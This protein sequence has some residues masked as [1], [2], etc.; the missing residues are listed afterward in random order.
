MIGP[1]TDSSSRR[2]RALGASLAIAGSLCAIPA[3]A[4]PP[5][6]AVD[7][8]LTVLHLS[9]SA[10]RAIR[11]DRL[12]VQLRVETTAGNPKQVQADINR[13]MG[14]ALAKVKTVTGV[15]PE[16]GSY[17][18]YE[19]RQ[20]NVTSR[21]RGSQ[22]LSLVDRD[23][24]ELLALVGDLQND[25]LAVSSLSFELSPEAAHTAQDE[26]TNEALNRLRDRAERI[27]MEL[28]L[29]FQ[30]YRDIRVGNVGGDRPVPMRAMAMA[31]AAPVAPPVGEAGDA[32]VQVSVEADVVLVPDDSKGP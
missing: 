14:N 22:S 13:R 23:F 10:D 28:H 25:G 6:P 17:A 5:S 7:E 21:W 32:M 1:A 11:R 31:T 20:Q 26:L 16:T 19:E 27:A 12:H 8:G 29:S 9:E 3:L 30:R 2:R 24:A 15:K 18:V 4:A